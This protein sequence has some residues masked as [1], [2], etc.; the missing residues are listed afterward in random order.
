MRACEVGLTYL[1]QLLNELHSMLEGEG[2]PQRSEL[3]LFG[4]ERDNSWEAV[5]GTVT[6]SLTATPHM[7]KSSG[8]WQLQMALGV[9]CHRKYHA[10]CPRRNSSPS[11]FKI[12]LQRL[13][14]SALCARNKHISSTASMRISAR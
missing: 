14:R 6:I 11:N 3:P 10:K 8:L 7:T 12:H 5:P 13:L 2:L 4:I 9:K 1:P